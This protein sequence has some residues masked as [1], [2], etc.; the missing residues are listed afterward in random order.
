MDPINDPQITARVLSEALPY[1]RR[2]AGRTVVV[3]RAAAKQE[4]T[5]PVEGSRGD[6]STTGQE[7]RVR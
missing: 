7:L 1:M 3:T 5:V 4:Y 6:M 2:Y